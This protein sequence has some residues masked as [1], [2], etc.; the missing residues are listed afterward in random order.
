MN[1]IQWITTILLLQHSQ[2]ILAH[3]MSKS[4]S[5][6]GV[7]QKMRLSL[8]G[9]ESQKDFVKYTNND[10]STFFLAQLTREYGAT[11]VCSAMEQIKTEDL[12]LFIRVL[13]SED[14]SSLFCKEQLLN[15]YNTYI[16]DQ[17]E[18]L[19]VKQLEKNQLQTFRKNQYPQ[20]VRQ[21]MYVSKSPSSIHRS[22]MNKGTFVLTFD[23][24]PHPKRT[25]HL[26]DIL[27]K[28]KIKALFFPIGKNVKSH[29]SVV[30]EIERRGHSIGSHTWSHP[31]LSK[32]P[33][34][35]ALREV[36]AGF[37]AITNILGFSDP[38]FRF[39]YMG[40]NNGVRS[41]LNRKN[42]HEFLWAI[43][44]NDWKYR[45]PEAL[46]NYSLKQVDKTGRGIIL[47]HDIQ[48]QTISIMPA[49]L[50]AM[51]HRGYSFTV[52]R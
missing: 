30:K 9:I 13:E 52:Y 2:M 49:F 45:N 27:D 37:D 36:Q 25:P 32:K 19:L 17:G 43:D 41:W 5:A 48:P 40:I 12:A 11:H 39:P 50:E 42:I 6:Q 18:K 21:P 1:F 34:N 15:K 14:L 33:T 26:L 46:L 10:G 22:R 38:F 51:I 24:G 28:Y 16:F 7:L 44:S 31:D 4:P 3:D 8:E 47:F 29:P 20:W 23:D 35:S